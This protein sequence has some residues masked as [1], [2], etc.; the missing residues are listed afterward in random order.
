MKDDEFDLYAVGI[1]SDCVEHDFDDY[2]LFGEIM[3]ESD[4]NYGDDL[5]LN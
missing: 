2:D 5:I 3:E 1:D 4:D